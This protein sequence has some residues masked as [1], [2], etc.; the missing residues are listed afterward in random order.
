MARIWHRTFHVFGNVEIVACVSV[1]ISLLHLL[2]HY[3]PP[4]HSGTDS[5]YI[6]LFIAA[7]SRSLHI[8]ATFLSAGTLFIF[9][10]ASLRHFNHPAA[11]MSSGYNSYHKK[12]ACTPLRATS[13]NSYFSLRERS[14]LEVQNGCQAKVPETGEIT[15]LISLSSPKTILTRPF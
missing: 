6:S 2:L 11:T 4:Y 7:F 1:V 12:R 5:L 9:L 14:F 15:S 8:T 13:T 3:L 10:S